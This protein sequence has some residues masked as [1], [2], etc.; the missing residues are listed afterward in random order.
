MDA[1]IGIVRES[2]DELPPDDGTGV[3]REMVDVVDATDRLRARDWVNDTV[4]SVYVDFAT[5]VSM[6]GFI[7]VCISVFAVRPVL[8]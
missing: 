4:R 8:S 7:I 5:F 3:T 6:V 2:F 1:G